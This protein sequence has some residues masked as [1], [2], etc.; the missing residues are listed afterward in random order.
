MNAI[1]SESLFG[2]TSGPKPQLFIPYHTQ[3]QIIN[4]SNYQS[5]IALDSLFLLLKKSNIYTK[6]FMLARTISKR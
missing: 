4:K 6:T 1:D 3:W 5:I 2:K